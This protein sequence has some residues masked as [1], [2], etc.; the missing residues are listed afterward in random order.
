MK[1]RFVIALL[2]FCNISCKE[3]EKIELPYS[4][5]KIID[6]MADV[7]LVESGGL[8]TSPLS[9]SLYQMTMDSLYKIHEIDSIKLADLRAL[10]RKDIEAYKII[11]NNIHKKLKSYL[12]DPDIK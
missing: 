6:I 11:E 10:L 8:K 4:D 7:R 12:D 2:V 1:Y 3:S 5:T 9:D